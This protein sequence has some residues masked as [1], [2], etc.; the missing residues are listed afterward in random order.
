MR[1]VHTE[2][3]STSIPEICGGAVTLLRAS[4]MDVMT[5]TIHLWDGN[6]RAESS[7]S[8][9]I[10]YT[11]GRLENCC[12]LVSIHLQSSLRPFSERAAQ[13]VSLGISAAA[14]N[15]WKAMSGGVLCFASNAHRQQPKEKVAVLVLSGLPGMESSASGGNTH[16]PP[17][18]GRHRPGR[19]VAGC[20]SCRRV[21]LIA[22]VWCCWPF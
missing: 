15:R 8:G 19:R 11:P 16:N 14:A 21:E 2:Y 1:Y 22:V 18:L 10:P 3:S 6:S 4:L 7:A 17:S 13:A 12:W 9:N 20:R 5:C